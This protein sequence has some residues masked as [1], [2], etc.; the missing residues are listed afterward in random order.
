MAFHPKNPTELDGDQ[1]S[2]SLSFTMVR[3]PF[4]M[5]AKRLP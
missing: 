2:L 1:R 5:G 4:A 3:V